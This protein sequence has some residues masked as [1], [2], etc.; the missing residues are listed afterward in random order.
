[1]GKRVAVIIKHKDRQYEGLRTSL[2]LLLEQHH[3]S[4]FVFDHEIEITQAYLE[5]MA[6]IDEM[7]GARYSN[8]AVNVEKYGF[9]PV[10]LEQAADVLRKSQIVIPF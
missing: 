7:G 4:M 8:V 10:A 2:G 1:M 9:I 3:V 6:F 5:N